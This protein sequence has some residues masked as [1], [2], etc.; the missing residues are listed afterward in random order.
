MANYSLSLSAGQTEFSIVEG[1]SAPGAGDIE[2]RINVANM[3]QC[4]PTGAVA[5]NGAAIQILNMFKNYL[6]GKSKVIY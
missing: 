1:T 6:S 4:D 5:P 2:L 3:P